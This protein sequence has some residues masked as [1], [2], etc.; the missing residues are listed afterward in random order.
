M[1]ARK[2]TIELSPEARSLLGGLLRSTEGQAII[3]ALTALCPRIKNEGTA[4]VMLASA[5]QHAGWELC[6]EQILAFIEPEQKAEADESKPLYPDLD[7][8]TVWEKSK[9]ENQ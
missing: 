3:D 2:T 7:D 1:I 9:S 8:D 6:V 4:E 5:H